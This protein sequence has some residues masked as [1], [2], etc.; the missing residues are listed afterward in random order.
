MVCR[1]AQPK[2]GSKSVVPEIL[3]GVLQARADTREEQKS[4]PKGSFKWTVLE[5]LQLAY[6]VTANSLYGQ[7]GARTSPVYCKELAASVTATGRNLIHFSKDHFEGSYNNVWREF[8]GK[9]YLV[10]QCR[11]VY[12]DTDSVFVKFTVVA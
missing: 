10:K 4:Y 8:N 9:K 6:K 11:T 7:C 12:G 3:R 1:Y 5:G 2:D